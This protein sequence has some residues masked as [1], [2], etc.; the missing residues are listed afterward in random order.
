[1]WA[2]QGFDAGRRGFHER[3]DAQGPRV[4]D[5]RRARVATRQVY[6]FARAP[7]LG[8]SGP[9]RQLVEAGLAF[10]LDHYRRPDGLFRTLVAADGAPLDERVWLYD[11]AFALLALASC[12][13]VLGARPMLVER[14]VQLREALYGQLRRPRGFSSGLSEPLP[15]LSNPHMHLFES[16]LAWQAVSTDPAWTVLAEEIGALALE[17]LIQPHGGL[18]ELFDEHWAALPEGTK[19]QAIEPG[20]QFEWCW[21]L[22]C[23]DAERC[24]PARRAAERLFEIGSG[25]G[26]VDGVA[27]NALRADFSVQDAAT[28][29]WPQ[30]EWLKAASLLGALTGQARYWEGAVAAA[31]ALQRFLEH[32]ARGLWHDKLTGAGGFVSEPAPAS[33][34]YHIVCAIAEFGAALQRA[35]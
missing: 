25:C 27:I 29:L 21:L 18:P 17:R 6:A 28:R 4:Q 15:L 12:Q 2:A 10:F 5:P 35:G 13:Q 16:A 19:G 22:L 30:T 3:L 8:W 14:G 26:I 11:Q 32:P 33:S 20:H 9:A 7:G 34:L 23:W 31:A 1:M 24:G